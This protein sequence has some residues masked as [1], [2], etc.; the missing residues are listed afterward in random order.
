MCFFL[1]YTG[2]CT[3][4][5]P[6]HFGFQIWS[7][8]DLVLYLFPFLLCCV[9]QF[10]YPWSPF[11]FWEQST[12][13][14][15]RWPKETLSEG[16]VCW[17]IGSSQLHNN[18]PLSTFP[19]F[20]DWMKD[21]FICM[22]AFFFKFVSSLVISEELIIQTEG[23]PVHECVTDLWN[24]LWLASISLSPLLLPFWPDINSSIKAW[25]V[26]K[27]AYISKNFPQFHLDL[28]E[29]G[30]W[31]VCTCIQTWDFVCA[32][33]HCRKHFYFYD[34]KLFLTTLLLRYRHPAFL[35]LFSIWIY[36]PIA[37]HQLFHLRSASQPLHRHQWQ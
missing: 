27:L 31:C 10:L 29:E 23:R 14:C 35:I 25:F 20:L 28:P 21:Y 9:S 26:V 3:F 11:G 12:V 15:W 2:N 24:A 18:I 33:I 4:T 37:H 8:F 13:E 30:W 1:L 16:E 19:E 34:P 32:L 36:L 6:S 7:F 22:V 5:Y 17:S